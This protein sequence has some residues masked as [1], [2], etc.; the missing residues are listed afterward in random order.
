[1]NHEISYLIQ[2]Y[3]FYNKIYSY[4]RQTIS[5]DLMFEIKNIKLT[6]IN[7]NYV[8][9][10]LKTYRRFVNMKPDGTDNFS[11]QKSTLAGDS[12]GR[13]YCIFSLTLLTIDWISSFLYCK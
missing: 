1:M 11:Y 5:K 4:A 12:F 3:P 10:G 8:D 2:S 9:D 13:D 7:I 6:I